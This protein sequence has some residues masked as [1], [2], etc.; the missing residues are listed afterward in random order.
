MSH[1]IRTPMNAI[2]GYTELM[3][4]NVGNI[5]K[6]KDYLSKIHSF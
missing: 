4:K 3:E 6:E 2:M 5:E 1:D